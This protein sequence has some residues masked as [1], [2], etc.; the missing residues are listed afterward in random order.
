MKKTKKAPNKSLSGKMVPKEEVIVQGPIPNKPDHKKMLLGIMGGALLVIILLAVGFLLRHKGGTEN[1]GGYDPYAVL[2]NLNPNP[3]AVTKS[4]FEKLFS[5]GD[6]IFDW[7]MNNN[8]FYEKQGS[9]GHPR[10][11]SPEERYNLARKYS[12]EYKM[13]LGLLRKAD[14]RRH[15]FVIKSAEISLDLSNRAIEALKQRNINEAIKDCN[16][17]IDIFPI[18]AKPYILLTKLYLMTGQE[19]KLYDILTLAGR[20]YPNFNNILSIVDDTDL[21]NIPLEEPQDNIYLADFPENKRAA[22]SFMFDDGE[23]DVYVNALPILDKYGF[24]ATIPVVAGLVAKSDEDTFWGSWAEWRDAADRGFEIADHSMDHRDSRELHGSDF[25][26]SIDQ[27]KEM[28]EKN[29][30][31][32]VTAYIFPHDSYDDEAVNRALREHE[33]VRTMEFLQSFYQKTFGVIYGGPN[34]SVK[35]AN[36]VVDIAIKRH[37]WILAN[38]HGVTTKQGVLSFKSITP[39]FLDDHLSHIHSKVNDVWVDTFTDIFEYMSR[40]SYTTIETKDSSGHSVDFVLH[41]FREGQKLTIPLTVIVKTGDG[42]T[43]ISAQSADGRVPKAWAC[44]PDKICIDVDS[45]DQTIH[46]QW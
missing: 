23:K 21:D 43:V 12:V 42:K 1:K 30:G 25:D 31:H 13:V 45:Y 6:E 18:N 7:L 24:K 5:N 35:T 4:T 32:K 38:C 15:Q 11:I 20:S 28:I 22:I 16:L 36:R 3:E 2:R 29:I 33:V 19:Q 8:Y 9:S 46:V 34:F 10:F 14:S 37:L 26:V 41:N 39:S 17:A 40:R 27:A 44:A